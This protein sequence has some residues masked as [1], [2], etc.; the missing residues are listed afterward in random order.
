MKQI[1]CIFLLM[2][3]Q[4]MWAQGIKIKEVKET[5]SGSD[6]FH[7]PVDNNGHPCGLVKILTTIDDLSFG[8]NVIGNVENKTNE[9]HVFLAKGSETL[10]IKRPHILPLTINFSD[11][12]I[13]PI[14]SKATYCVTLKE[15][16][17]N[18]SKN[19]VIVNVR[20]FQ[21]KV[22]VDEI[23]I[24][25]ENND[26]SYQL[27]L[28][29]GD[30]IFRFEE[31]GYRP[32]VQVIKVGKGTQDLTVELESLLAELDVTCQTTTAEIWIE[33]EIKG[34][35]AWKGKLPAGKYVVEARLKD[36]TSLKKEITLEEKG[37][38]SLLINQLKRA[39]GKVFF[40]NACSES[41]ISIDGKNVK[42]VNG[43]ATLETGKHTVIVKMPFGYKEEMYYVDI[44]DGIT[45]TIIIKCEPLNDNY[46]LAFEGDVEKQLQLARKS[47]Y[48]DS[49]QSNYWYEK[50]FENLESLN[51]E[52]FLSN[53]F[54]I[55]SHFSF[56]DVKKHLKILLKKWAI[57]KGW[58]D[59]D[60]KHTICS[61]I[62]ECYQSLSDFSS[63]IK[64]RMKE[65]EIANKMKG[66]FYISYKD[67]A[68]TYEQ[69]GDK[70]QAI[71]W[72]KK[73]AGEWG[74]IDNKN[75]WG[76]ATLELA[77]AYLRLGYNKEAAEIYR[78]FIHKSPDD[79]NCSDWRTKLR[80]TGF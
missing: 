36:Y 37:Y 48:N 61:N 28:P 24:D 56:R 73:A 57:N 46:R 45:D 38:R 51:E 6:A 63:A 34:V 17:M 68:E 30:H 22:S 43:V 4:F 8:G 66:Y 25:N 40:K 33:D 16:K 67:L 80:K 21:T 70:A 39:Q 23:L 5:V 3:C 26:G 76:W 58:R 53:Y 64:W 62:A 41:K 49:I 72:Y 35:G 69:K 47:D 7:A 65:L 79:A 75:S 50:V 9:Y 15:E 27:I 54:E 2:W 14:A 78:Y 29:K 1:S 44:H 31:K 10:I 77:D 12:G 74:N 71:S 11:Y 52:S 42:N 20:P 60:E 13:A 32:S 59:E 19:G 18:A 55:K